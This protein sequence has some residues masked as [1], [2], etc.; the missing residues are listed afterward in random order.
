MVEGAVSEFAR[1]D[2]AFNNAGGY[3]THGLL[4]ELSP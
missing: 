4:H 2:F 3:G 1:L